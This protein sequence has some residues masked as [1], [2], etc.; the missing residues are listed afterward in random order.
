[1]AARAIWKG[2]VKIG[3]QSVPVKLYSAVQ[4]RR[5]HFRLLHKTDHEPVKQ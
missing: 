3:T 1:M 5:I 2:V 4:E